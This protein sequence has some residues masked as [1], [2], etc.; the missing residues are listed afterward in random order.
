MNS[1]PVADQQVALCIL[2]EL[3]VQ[4]ATL[5]HMLDI[6]LLLLSVWSGARQKCDNRVA[7]QLNSAPLL[8]LLQR[9]QLIQS[10]NGLSGPGNA[11]SS[12]DNAEG[13]HQFWDEVRA[14]LKK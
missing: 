13:P 3:A 8:P 4:R 12:S 1:V 5:S 2:T 14:L 11:R 7:S 6:I 10:E 9:F